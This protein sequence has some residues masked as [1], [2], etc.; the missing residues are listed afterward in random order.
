MESNSFKDKVV[1]ISGG[2][3]DIGQAVALEFG[4]MGAKME[5]RTSVTQQPQPQNCP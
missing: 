3:G 2:M 4:K 5:Y 1:L